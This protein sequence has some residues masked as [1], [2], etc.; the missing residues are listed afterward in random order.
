MME[1]TGEVKDEVSPEQPTHC[2]SL[3]RSGQC[4]S[5]RCPGLSV[6]AGVNASL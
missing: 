6:I 2:C 4:H 5:E 3:L 1:R